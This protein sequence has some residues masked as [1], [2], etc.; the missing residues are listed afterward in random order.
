MML[1]FVVMPIVTRAAQIVGRF[2]SRFYKLDVRL[3]IGSVYFSPFLLEILITKGSRAYS[4]VLIIA[5]FY[6]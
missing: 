4:V 5:S 1:C 2:L 6:L 3:Y